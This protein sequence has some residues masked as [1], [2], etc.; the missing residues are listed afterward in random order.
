MESLLLLFMIARFN[1]FFSRPR[2][3]TASPEVAPAVTSALAELT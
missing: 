2:E 1:K 3:R